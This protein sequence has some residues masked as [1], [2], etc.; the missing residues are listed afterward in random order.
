MS[1]ERLERRVVTPMDVS[2]YTGI[3]WNL[4]S[5]AWQNE[6]AG[7][8]G[9]R[10]LENLARII[11][12][13]FVYEK[14]AEFF[15]EG[16]NGD[17]TP[18]DLAFT[19]SAS[20]INKQARFMFGSPVQFIIAGEN[21]DDDSDAIKQQISALQT[22]V[23]NVMEKGSFADKCL[24]GF[25]DACIGE[26][27]AVT[28]DFNPGNITIKFLPSYAFIYEM[29][30]Y[31]NLSKIVTFFTVDDNVEKDLQRIYKK[32]WM[33][34]NNGFCE[35]TE[36]IFD[37]NGLVVEEIS[38]PLVTKFTYIPAWVILNDGLTGDEDGE[39]DI[40][41]LGRYEEWYSKLA[42]ADID[43]GRQ[44]MN[45]VRWAKDLS[46]ES[47]AGLS[48]AP[49]AFWDVTSDQEIIGTDGSGKG[50][51]G[52]LETAMNYSEPLSNTLERIASAMN[53][54]VD[55][56]NISADSMT[57]TLTSGKAL[58]AI[59]WPLSVR[60]DE[61]MIAWKPALRFIANTIIEGARLYPESAKPYSE[62]PITD[63]KYTLVV[64]NPYSLPEDVI[65]E[66]TID[67]QGVNAQVMSRKKYIIKWQKVTNKEADKELEQIMLEKQMLEGGFT[68]AMA[69]AAG[70][71]IAPAEGEAEPLT[72]EEFP[73]LEEIELEEDGSDDEIGSL[74]DELD[75]LA[76]EL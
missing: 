12:Y 42:N 71:A 56:P 28:L 25:K 19:R 59:Y 40:K 60:C 37:G 21:P 34:N 18:A 67:L 68:Q 55:V 35:I 31:E 63:V 4:F 75:A 66:K 69:G 11:G 65:E 33:M 46:P 27:V 3:P 61:K 53:E 44:G 47:T 10:L 62:N 64:E 49:G 76:G 23:D 36:E 72:D 58:K 17:Y 30:Q 9:Q 15:L 43:A 73:E 26:R 5:N 54:D 38:K 32:R 39:S 57:G 2:A 16:S 8:Y 50:E 45:P 41:H 51:L 52:V 74:L 70:S 1:T 13:Y 14:G 24:K 22:L 20:L 6:V 7:I 29:D 48:I